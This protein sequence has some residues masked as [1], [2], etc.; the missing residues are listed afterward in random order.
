VRFAA[1]DLAELRR[2]IQATRW[3]EPETVNDDTQ[4]VPLATMQALARYWATD[5]SPCAP[6]PA[7]QGSQPATGRRAALVVGASLSARAQGEGISPDGAGMP[8][9]QQHD[10]APSL[11]VM[12][13]ILIENLAFAC[14]HDV[15]IHRHDDLA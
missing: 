9:P 10:G 7:T 5:A 6:S 11:L 2:R 15:R 12:P 8:D 3:P 1:A 13:T 4:G 14:G